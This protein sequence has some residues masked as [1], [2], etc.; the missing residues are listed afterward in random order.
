MLKLI[1]AKQDAPTITYDLRLLTYGYNPQKFTWEKLDATLPV[2]SDDAT[3][4]EANGNTYWLTKNSS[5]KALELYQLIPTTLTFTKVPSANVPQALIP[6]PPKR[7]AQY[8]LG[9]YRR[10]RAFG[11]PVILPIGKKY[12]WVMC[13]FRNLLAKV[14]KRCASGH[15]VRANGPHRVL[16]LHHTEWAGQTRGEGACRLPR[17]RSVRI[18]LPNRR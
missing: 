11:T 18:H 7:W 1:I 4:L 13:Y 12:R 15:W 6:F 3:V 17:Q 2:A 8:L 9:A 5:T 10:G 14:V 16:Q